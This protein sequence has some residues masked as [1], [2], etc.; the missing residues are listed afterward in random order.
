[1]FA[2]EYDI[3]TDQ[4]S[5]FVLSVTWKNSAGTPIDLTGYSGNMQ[6]RVLPSSATVVYDFSTAAGSI[7]LGG[8]LGTIVVTGQAATMS[9]AGNFMYDLKLSKAGAVTRLL[10]GSF[11]VKAVVTK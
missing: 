4:L 8:A 9:T 1:M 11:T 7:V 3:E 6:V 5:T 2:E 10:S